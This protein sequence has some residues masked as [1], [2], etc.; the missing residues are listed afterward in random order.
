MRPPAFSIP[1]LL[2]SALW[3]EEVGLG[4]RSQLNAHLQ[5]EISVFSREI[6]LHIIAGTTTRAALKSIM[7]ED[8][9]NNVTVVDALLDRPLPELSFKSMRVDLVVQWIAHSLGV[10]LKAS[11]PV[12][13]IGEGAQVPIG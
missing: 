7:G 4:L 2:I 3:A 11:G 13:L 5:I 10:P 1:L 12:I 8:W 9:P 6:D